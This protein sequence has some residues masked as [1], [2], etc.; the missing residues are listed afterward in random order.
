[1]KPTNGAA[2]GAV[3]APAIEAVVFD[4]DGTLTK[5]GSP[6][7]YLHE[8]LGT[9][10]GRGE[11]HLRDFQEG[12][13]DYDTFARLDAEAWR[14][15][16]RGE[17]RRLVKEIEWR[18]GVL[19]TLLAQKTAGR[20]IALLSSGLT[21]ITDRVQDEFGDIADFVLANEVLFRFGRATGRV[22]VRV[23][24][25][26]KAEAL[27]QV[28]KALG[29]PP[30]RMAHV[31]D[32]SGD[33]PVFRRV[34]LSV[35]TVD[36]PEEVK[37][38]AST[39]LTSVDLR[40]LLLVPG[41]QGAL[42]GD[43]GG[44]GDGDSCVDGRREAAAAGGGGALQGAQNGRPPERNGSLE[45]L[46]QG[47]G[48]AIRR[49]TRGDL[50]YLY[51]LFNDPDVGYYASA[52]RMPRMTWRQLEQYHAIWSKGEP[53]AGV[54]LIIEEAGQDIGVLAYTDYG[55]PGEPH[56]VMGIA[57]DAGHWGRGL[58]P[59]SI[60]LFLR[61]AFETL[62]Y[63]KV[64]L[65]VFDHNPRAR[66]AFEKCGFRPVQRVDARHYLDGRRVYTTVMEVTPET[67]RASQAGQLLD[68]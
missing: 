35:A 39:V 66:K 5:V 37:Q 12:R 44:Y 32:G 15:V 7:Q 16:R 65:D 59:R 36:A 56:V 61:Y 40:S 22:A 60:A 10:T 2:P 31:G 20:K 9:W 19:D 49:V 4:V 48:L 63:A 13:I 8:R 38:A 3:Q 17:M 68:G 14:G 43:G 18:P 6:W 1:M 27:D 67:F 11:R 52:S 53:A 62:G 47:L 55:S 46:G 26:G 64:E 57:L 51:H 28:V 50:K 29:V 23:P 41:L 45:V 34:A 30:E 58:G 25:K 54:R 21:L 33:I 24:W 42:D